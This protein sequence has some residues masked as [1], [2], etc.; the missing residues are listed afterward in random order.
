M[1]SSPTCRGK[2][3]WHLAVLTATAL[4]AAPVLAQG[5]WPSRP[6]R[7]V[8]PS[9]GG[10]GPDVLARV[11]AE[12]I[13][14]ALK[15]PVVVDNKPGAN[16]Q[17]S[18]DAVV[19]AQPD[20]YTVLLA[21]A[22][23]TVMNQAIQPKLPFNIVDDLVPVAQIGSGG[24][25]LVVTP[26]FPARDMKSFV[27]TV[28]AQPGKYDYGSWGIGSG[29]H[30]AMA[31]LHTLAGIDLTHVPYKGVPPILADLQGGV[32]KIAFVDITTSV[33]LVK[34]GKIRPLGITGKRRAPAFP[35]VPTMAEQGF[36]MTNEGWYGLFVPKGT[37]REIVATLN[38]EINKA[39]RSPALGT[40]FQQLN[41]MT[42]PPLTTPDEF[43][44]AVR[45]DYATW[46]N[47]VKING[48]K[49]E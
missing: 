3:A 41:M 45:N 35:D 39:L 1:K 20:G 42:D 32:L 34:S 22:S 13:S 21:S 36:P 23:A 6:I 15:Q 14:Q 7:M 9:P 2:R 46:A 25:L 5:T 11:F 16:G 29:G 4:A 31:Q 10:S 38:R 43:A 33:P 48:I 28:K 27:A 12:Q 40:R 47:V 37:P 18:V 44:R 19:R 8:V 30:L 17:L 26:D 49:P 24:V